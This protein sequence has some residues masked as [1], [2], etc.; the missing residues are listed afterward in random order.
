M[1]QTV[2]GKFTFMKGFDYWLLV[3][4]L[5]LCVIGVIFVFSGT[6]DQ[7]LRANL[8][9]NHYML[10]HV[11]FVGFGLCFMAFGALLDYSLWKKFSPIC[12]FGGVLLLLLVLIMGVEVKGAKRWLMIAGVQIQPS[13]IMK[14]GVA[15]WVSAKFSV[16]KYPISDWKDYG[17]KM[18]QSFGV[19]LIVALLLA[20]Q[21]NFSMLLIISIV[22]FAV[23]IT[24]DIPKKYILGT[25]GIVFSG[26]LLVGLVEQYRIKR[27]MGFL[28][29]EENAQGSAYQ[30]LNMMTAIGNGG[31]TGKG[32]GEGTQKLGYVPEVHTDGAFALIGEELGYIGTL[33]IFACFFIIFYRGLLI[34]DNSKS[35]FGKYLAICI[36][37]FIA[38]NMLIHVAV[39]LGKFPTTGQ[40]LP[41]ISMGGSN[42]CM[43][44]FMIGV[45]L[46]ISRE[47]T[48]KFLSSDNINAKYSAQ[49]ARY[50][51]G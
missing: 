49:K 8:P 7:A 43:N 42:L 15:V 6:S 45:L 50:S 31:L 14:F 21:P 37:G 16:L 38:L 25:G 23:L 9:A 1:K 22:C 3:C 32:L 35:N 30:A 36:V 41:F 28:N 51:R 46:N 10:R 12:F 34:A 2:K 33:I 27:L 26:L 4:V 5:A 48:G 44:M 11:G 47:N 39:C 40:P 17:Q 24:A 20:L 29:P 19:L 18:L 13:E